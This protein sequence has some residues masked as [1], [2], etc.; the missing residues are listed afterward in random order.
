MKPLLRILRHRLILEAISFPILPSLRKSDYRWKIE[1]CVRQRNKATANRG[2]RQNSLV[3]PS[4]PLS[5]QRRPLNVVSIGLSLRL[6]LGALTFYTDGYGT[7][8]NLH[9]RRW[10]DNIF[11][12][13]K[14]LI[15]DNIC[16]IVFLL[17]LIK[18][19][20]PLITLLKSCYE[21]IPFYENLLT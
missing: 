7:I 4:F 20:N 12:K 8:C 21:I 9:Q 15:F 17:D 14:L 6:R 10:F 16:F 5:A 3:R 2:L 11:L 19:I 18:Y 1:T 13:T